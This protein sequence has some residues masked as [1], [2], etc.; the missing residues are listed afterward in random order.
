MAFIF[1]ACYIYLKSP[2]FITPV[3]EVFEPLWCSG[4]APTCIARLLRFGGWGRLDIETYEALRKGSNPACGKKTSR[5]RY[6]ESTG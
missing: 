1:A 5:A 4:C 6:P 2:M 3:P